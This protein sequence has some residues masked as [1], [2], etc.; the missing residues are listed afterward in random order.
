MRN[1]YF[2]LEDDQQTGRRHP[3]LTGLDEATRIIHGSYRLD[4]KP[5]TEF[6][7][8]PLTLIS[9]Y[10]D[11]PM[12]KVYARVKTDVAELYLREVGPGRVVY[13]PWDIGGIFWGQDAP[14]CWWLI[15]TSPLTRM[16]RA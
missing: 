7:H 1:A 5:R 4:I 2:R 13:F 6:L 16:A 10:S 11:L 9:S 15:E 14:I 12:E 8:P 3:I